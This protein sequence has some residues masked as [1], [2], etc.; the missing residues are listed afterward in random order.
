[1]TSIKKLLSVSVLG[2]AAVSLAVPSVSAFDHHGDDKKHE[3]MKDKKK[4]KEKMDEMEDLGPEAAEMKKR[5]HEEWDA[6]MKRFKEET[7][8]AKGDGAAMK[9]LKASHKA[10]K[11]AMKERHKAEWKALKEA[12]G[13]DD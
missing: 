9:E 4:H 12:S 5:H 1:M 13:S 11:K 2:L 10:E 8:A 3:K 6:M 7:K